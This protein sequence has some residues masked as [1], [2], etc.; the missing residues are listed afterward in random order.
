MHGCPFCAESAHGSTEREPKF[1]CIYDVLGLA[2]G[3][4][5]ITPIP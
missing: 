4:A 3:P 2:P 5:V 1:H